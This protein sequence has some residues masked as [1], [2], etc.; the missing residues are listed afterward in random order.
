MNAEI[1][2]V[3]R[4]PPRGGKSGGGPPSSSERKRAPVKPLEPTLEPP[5][6]RSFSEFSLAPDIQ[7]AIA[8]MG[9]TTPT[10]IQRLAIEPVLAG[11]D[12][13]A[14]AETGTG[15]TLAFGSPMM[16]KID[17]SRRTVLGLVLAPTRELADQVYQV[18]AQLGAPRGV[19]VALVVGG[20]PMD[21]QL[22][23]LQAGSQVVV[24]TPGRVLDLL[25]RRIMA[26]PWCEYV[27]LDEADIMLEIGFLE[28]VRKILSL[29][30]KERQ[31]LLFSATFPPELLSLARN[32]TRDPIEVATASG[33]STVT[34]IHQA[35]IRVGE[36][37]AHLA[38]MRLVESSR[39]E[40]VFLVFCSKR[41]D[42]DRLSR[43]ISSLRARVYSLH[44]GFE[45]DARFRVLSAFRSGEI[46]VLLAT[47]VASR[48]LD[49]ARV[50][51][52]VNWSVPRDVSIYTHRIGRTGRAGRSGHAVTFV[53]GLDFRKWR[54]ILDDAPWEVEELPFP[55][56]GFQWRSPEPP[57]PESDRDSRS[58]NEED[59]REAPPRRSAPPDRAPP[60]RPSRSTAS[61]AAATPPRRTPAGPRAAPRPDPRTKAPVRRSKPAPKLELVPPV[62]RLR[63]IKPR[64]P[65]AVRR[66]PGTKNRVR[67]R[68][69]ARGR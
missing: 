7:A 44:G 28:D 6:I 8:A 20:E 63:R 64:Q 31:T 22:R 19:K 59:Q 36:D 5:D 25:Q 10:P 39:P 66:S 69:L 27:V 65:R 46:K 34:T 16:S 53:S 55:T 68:R 35:W 52:V 29:I 24:G 42:V 48:G 43:R 30:P 13:I 11:R 23:A 45:Q 60:P 14:K 62:P 3:R 17:S 50:T 38:L 1:E 4:A 37:D 51:H 61:P 57:R 26:L 40:D 9:I 18:L 49:V 33:V 2:F 56:R 54:R 47:D 12:V 21:Q 32:N 58:R 67:A 41:T 15:K